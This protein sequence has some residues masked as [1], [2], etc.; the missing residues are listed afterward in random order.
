MT[1]SFDR[2]IVRRLLM[3]RS[4][5]MTGR[6]LVDAPPQGNVRIMSTY[7]M[8]FAA[9]PCAT[10]SAATAMQHA[11]PTPARTPRHRLGVTWNEMSLRCRFDGALRIF[12]LPAPFAPRRNG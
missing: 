11:L 12:R 9:S 4:V 1:D 8:A 2:A 3:P 6:I 10:P 7:V 5:S